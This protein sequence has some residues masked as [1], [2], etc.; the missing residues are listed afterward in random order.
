MHTRQHTV[1]LVEELCERIAAI[2][3]QPKHGSCFDNNRFSIHQKNQI[4]VCNE[5][6]MYRIQYKVSLPGKS[7]RRASTRDMYTC[8]GSQDH[9]NVCDRR[10]FISLIPL[11]LPFLD[12][13]PTAAAA[14]PSYDE[15]AESYDTLDD[16]PLASLLGMDGQRQRLLSRARG[17]VLEVG[18]GT[19]INLKFYDSARVHSLT[20]LDISEK[21][22]EQA[23]SKRSLLG[24]TRSTFIQGS[25]EDLPFPDDTFDTIIDTFSLCVY[26]D[27][28][29]AIAEMKRVVKKDGNVLL[30]EHARSK[31]PLLGAYQDL[32]AES[33]AT[34]GKG[35]YWN[36]DVDAILKSNGLILSNREEYLGGL[37]VSYILAK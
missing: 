22:L 10:S 37:L 31:A 4:R 33:V 19:G 27:P 16:G 21:M 2:D 17:D 5:L 26:S 24:G 32:T 8:V 36:Q 28:G 9:A 15:Y 3:G 29:R 13:D 25:V 7:S 20:A 35:C 30:L 18:V 23:R 6:S 34:L 1:F 11:L 14:Q 12:A